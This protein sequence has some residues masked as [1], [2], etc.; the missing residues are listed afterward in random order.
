MEIF[1]IINNLTQNLLEI[2]GVEDLSNVDA[3]QAR[4]LTKLVRKKLKEVEYMKRMGGLTLVASN[5]AI[6]TTYHTN[7]YDRRK[8]KYKCA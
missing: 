6:F 8:A 5:D 7:S 2:L 1:M 4:K 3:K